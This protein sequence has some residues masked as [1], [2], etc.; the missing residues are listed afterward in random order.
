MP[1]PFSSNWIRLVNRTQ[2]LL[3]VLAGLSCAVGSTYAQSRWFEDVTDTHLPQ[4][5]GLHTLDV[6]FS[7]VDGDGDLDAAIAVEN[8]PNRFYLNDGEGRLTNQEGAFGEGGYD[9]EHVRTADFNEDGNPDVI[10]VAE[11]D[12]HHQYFLGRG[13]G[14]FRDVTGRLPERSEGNALDVGDVDGDGRP[15]V[16]VGN[17]GEEGQNLLWL[18][19]PERPGHFVDATASHL[20]QENDQTQGIVLKDVD[21][22][23]DLDMVVGN[24]VPPNRL[25]INEGGGHFSDQSGRLDLPVPLHTRQVLAFDATGD[26]RVDIVYCNLTSNGS[27]WEKDPQTRLLVQDKE[28][29]F[30]DESGSRMPGNNFSTYACT[31][32]DVDDDGDQD[33]ILSTIEIPGFNPLPVRAY[34]NDGSGNFTDVTAEVLPN[35]TAGR[36]WGTDVGDLDGDGSEDLFIGGFGTQARLLFGRASE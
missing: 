13:D 30:T 21:G 7:D 20:P 22:D 3:L 27:G 15:D 32:M 5:P 17:T 10:F 25:L 36:N 6:S 18:N 11:D 34:A 28:G 23:Q 35:E 1:E 26:S 12:R 2:P 33:L 29:Q 16:V 8:E 24:E 14:T 4:A 9:T 31:N 19:D